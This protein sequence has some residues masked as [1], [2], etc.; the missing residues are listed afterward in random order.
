MP[1]LRRNVAL[2]AL[3]GVGALVAVNTLTKPSK[4]QSIAAGMR[5]QLDDYN[6]DIHPDSTEQSLN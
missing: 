4:T 5:R 2:T 3:A 6:S 1:A